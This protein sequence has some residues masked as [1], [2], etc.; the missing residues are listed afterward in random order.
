MWTGGG[1]AE[2]KRQSP[3]SCNGLTKKKTNKR[4]KKTTESLFLVIVHLPTSPW[5]CFFSM[6]ILTMI[7]ISTTAAL[8]LPSSSSRCSFLMP[9]PHPESSFVS[10]RTSSKRQKSILTLGKKLHKKFISC[11]PSSKRPAPGSLPSNPFLQLF[12]LKSMKTQNNA[13]RYM[14]IFFTRTNLLLFLKSESQERGELM[15]LDKG[16]GGLWE[17]WDQGWEG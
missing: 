7:T 5:L 10:T 1:E 2:R 11:R 9:P 16:L 8:K 17:G 3:F 13:S 14:M 6:L 15:R 4:H 12:C